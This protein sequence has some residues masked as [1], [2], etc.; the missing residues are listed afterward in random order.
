MYPNLSD[1]W[2]TAFKKFESL[3]GIRVSLDKFRSGE[4]TPQEIWDESQEKFKKLYCEVNSILTPEDIIELKDCPNCQGGANI[5]IDG[6]EPNCAYCENC[7]LS[8][9]E[10]WYEYNDL[11]RV[12]NNLPRR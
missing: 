10:E 6:D 12:W 1:E 9:A 8:I 2:E 7:G 5:L 4:M 3:T 11:A